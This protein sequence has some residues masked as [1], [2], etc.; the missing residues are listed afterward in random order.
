MEVNNKSIWPSVAVIM[1]SYNHSMYVEAS[2]NSILT[3]NYKN[4]KLVVIDDC[5]TDNSVEI[6]DR[7]AKK[8]NFQFIRN[9]ENLGLNKSLQKA[10]DMISSDYVSF[11]ASDDLIVPTKISE[12]I[13]YLLAKSIDA[14]YATGYQLFDDGR[15]KVINLDH[16]EKKFQRN[17]ILDYVYI[18]DSSGPLLQS[19]LF[20][21]NIIKELVKVR[22]KFKSDDWALMIK[23]LEFAKVDFINKPL[24]YYRQHSDNSHNKYWTTFSMRAEVIFHLTPLA[25]RHVAFANLLSSQA[26]YLFADKKYILGIRFSLSALMMDFRV[27]QLKPLIKQ[28]AKN[29]LVKLKVMR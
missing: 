29:V 1:P 20:K 5:S 13:E 23:I 9:S 25:L 8:H 28:I 19:G 10:L 27:S 18:T 22:D 17:K 7:L 2:I 14:V 3:Q 11:L 26:Q 24:F 15:T 12:Q 21:M 4:I 6:I 16:I